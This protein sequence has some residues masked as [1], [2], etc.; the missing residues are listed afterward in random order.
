MKRKKP[1]LPRGKSAPCNNLPSCDLDVP[2]ILTSTAG[3]G[4]KRSGSRSDQLT[5]VQRLNKTGYSIIAFSHTIHGKVSEDDDAFVTIPSSVTDQIDGARR[6]KLE[7]GKLRQTSTPNIQILRRLNVIVKDKSDLSPF[8]QGSS[9]SSDK[10]QKVLN[11]YDI[12]ALCPQ[13]DITFSTACASTHLMCSDIITLDYTAG[14]GGIQL[15]YK[16]RTSDIAAATKRGITFELPYGTALIDSSKRKALVQTAK[17]FSNACLGVRNPHPPRIIISSGKRQFEG[18]DHGAMTLRSAS[19]MKNFA[20]IV[21]GFPDSV[22]SK[23]L[24]E[25]AVEAITRGNNRKNGKVFSTKGGALTEI[26]ASLT[27]EN[28]IELNQF[29]FVHENDGDN[30]CPGVSMELNQDTANKSGKKNDDF[31]D[32]FLSLS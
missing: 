23:I 2:L 22:V 27:G 20:K 21:L 24:S 13:D 18:R 12:I 3:H 31:G 15:P 7:S 17:I 9:T 28:T 29:S 30:L 26:Y 19:D 25:H 1:T 6:M 4:L 14:A 32:D 11:S 10:I 16:I 5:L 8:L